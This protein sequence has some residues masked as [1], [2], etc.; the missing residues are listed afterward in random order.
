MILHHK[1]S[2]LLHWT[3]AQRLLSVCCCIGINLAALQWRAL[4]TAPLNKQQSCSD[5][6]VCMNWTLAA[7]LSC[8]P[9]AA[10]R[11]SIY[12]LTEADSGRITVGLN[13]GRICFWLHFM[14]NEVLKWSTFQ[15][16]CIS[17]FTFPA[18]VIVNFSL[19][20]SMAH[21]QHF[22]KNW[23]T[24][25]TTTCVWSFNQQGSNW[26]ASRHLGDGKR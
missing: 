7:Y 25:P 5:H 21:S 20:Y 22:L 14:S 12:S 26:R 13:S 6:S 9:T 19:L 18:W 16:V 8:S 23:V 10:G 4:P 2:I 15:I 17:S 1:F 11:R 3:L 24:Q